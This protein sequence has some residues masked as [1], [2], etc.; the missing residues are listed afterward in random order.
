MRRAGGLE[1]RQ[2]RRSGVDGREDNVSNRTACTAMRPAAVCRDAY[3]QAVHEIPHADLF[4]EMNR[5][6]AEHILRDA[7]QGL[8]QAAELRANAAR[9]LPPEQNKAG[10][11]LGAALP[12]MYMSPDQESE[13]Q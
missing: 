6:I 3:D 12:L 11:T 9:P 13:K 2:Q 7:D 10:G 4:S 1:H 8:S 5:A